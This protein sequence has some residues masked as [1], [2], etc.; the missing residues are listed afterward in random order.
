VCWAIRA[1]PV[2]QEPA[3]CDWTGNQHR[4]GRTVVDRI[5][6]GTGRKPAREDGMDHRVVDREL[7]PLA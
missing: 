1:G 5:A 4:V 6:V 2:Q 3:P 7:C